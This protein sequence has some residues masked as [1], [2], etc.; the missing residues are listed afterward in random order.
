[1]QLIQGISTKIQEQQNWFL[2]LVDQHGLQN[3][4]VYD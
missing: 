1:M 2:N 3:K 4:M